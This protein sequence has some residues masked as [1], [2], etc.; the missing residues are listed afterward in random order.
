VRSGEK[1]LKRYAVEE[2]NRYFEEAFEL[3]TQHGD[4]SVET[5]IALLDLLI[6][7]S[8]VYYYRGDYRGLLERLEAH[9]GLVESLPDKSRLGMFYGWLG[10]AK[11]HRELFQEAYQHLSTALQLGEETGISRSSG[12]HA[13]GWPDLGGTGPLG[14]GRRLCQEGADTA[15]SWRSRTSTCISIPWRVGPC[16]LAQGERQKTFEAGHG[17]FRPEPSQYP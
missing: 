3:L 2:S 11:W 6:K 8:Q 1:S 4:H 15:A 7:W 5:Q 10:C 13:P 14:R 9:M 12:M 16:A 17:L